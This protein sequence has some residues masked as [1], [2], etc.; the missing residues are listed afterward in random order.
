MNPHQH[1]IINLEK[2]SDKQISTITIVDQATHAYIMIYSINKI[3]KNN[4]SL[5]VPTPPSH[6]A[7]QHF[8][9]IFATR[10]IARV[11]V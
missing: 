10:E 3:I 7:R 5:I 11:Q 8:L 4:I 6:F 9:F 1:M 2:Y